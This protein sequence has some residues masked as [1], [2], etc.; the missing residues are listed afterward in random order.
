MAAVDVPTLTARLLLAHEWQLLEHAQQLQLDFLLQ[1]A[2]VKAAVL[3]ALSDGPFAGKGVRAFEAVLAALDADNCQGTGRLTGATPQE[4]K[5]LVLRFRS[6]FPAP[7]DG[8]PW[9]FTLALS[10][11]APADLVA[12][13]ADLAAGGG[14]DRVWVRRPQMY[15]GPM[16]QSLQLAIDPEAHAKGKAKGKG[17]KGKGEGGKDKGKAGKGKAEAD[18]GK[19][20]AGKDKAGAGALVAPMAAAAIGDVAMPAA[21][22]PHMAPPGS[23]EA[24][25][26]P[27]GHASRSPSGARDAPSGASA[28]SAA[29]AASNLLREGGSGA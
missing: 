3:T 12:A 15:L 18:K 10:T 26:S 25:R 5:N 4:L 11:S 23:R 20:E 17:K 8:K 13:V 9:K 2:P 7:L 16:A 21:V 27:R 24:S 1:S 19:A 28:S 6:K 22:V 14:S 29:A